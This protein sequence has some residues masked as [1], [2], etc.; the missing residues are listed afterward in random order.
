MFN[1]DSTKNIFKSE[2]SKIQQVFFAPRK[3]ILTE[4]YNFLLKVYLKLK[5]YTNINNN[6]NYNIY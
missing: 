2:F 3:N 6:N 5:Y 4:I 1:E